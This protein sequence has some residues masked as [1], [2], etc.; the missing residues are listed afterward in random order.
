MRQVVWLV[1]GVVGKCIPKS[2]IGKI[3]EQLGVVGSR[4]ANQDSWHK[5]S[6]EIILPHKR[7]TR[8]RKFSKTNTL[9]MRKRSG[10][11]T[12]AIA[13][14]FSMPE[15]KYG[16]LHAGTSSSQTDRGLFISSQRL[17]ITPAKT[18]SRRSSSI[19]NGLSIAVGSLCRLKS[20]TKSI[21]AIFH[22]RGSFLNLN[23]VSAAV[24]IA[25]VRHSVLS[26]IVLSPPRS[27]HYFPLM[28]SFATVC[29]CMFEVPS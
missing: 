17:S 22:Q 23:L 3:G 5:T 26:G 20:S 4:V 11:S 21:N 18:A 28:I 2:S 19:R 29:S 13:L 1:F 25:E 10:L 8:L 9:R 24:I 14:R 27:S 12:M 7:H 16:S 6:T 15:T